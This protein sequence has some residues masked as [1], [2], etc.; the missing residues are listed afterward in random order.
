V[1]AGRTGESIPFFVPSPILLDE[2]KSKIFEWVDSRRGLHPPLL[3]GGAGPGEE[4][5]QGFAGFLL[6]CQAAGMTPEQLSITNCQHHLGG[7]PADSL[8]VQR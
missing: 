3:A 4:A 8:L 1:F 2:G 5:T 7:F 6:R